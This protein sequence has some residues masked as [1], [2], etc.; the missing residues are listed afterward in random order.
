MLVNH[1]S[2]SDN[3]L[4]FT[5]Q[6][7]RRAYQRNSCIIGLVR[8]AVHYRLRA[9]NIKRVTFAVHANR[10]KPFVDPALRPIEPPIDDDDPSEPYLDE[11]DIPADSFEVSES[12]SHDNNTNFIAEKHDACSPSHS[13]E[14]LERSNQQLDDEQ[15]VI[16]G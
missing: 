16:D 13:Q 14:A 8:T 15:V 7:R 9:K 2:K 4:G 3:V 5:H 10:M 1:F 11:S 12:S 6:K